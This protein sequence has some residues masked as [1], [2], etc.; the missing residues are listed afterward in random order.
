MRQCADLQC[1]AGV[2]VCSQRKQVPQAQAK[3]MPI[4]QA[5]LTVYNN[6]VA[7]HLIA[8]HTILVLAHKP[9][10]KVLLLL[11]FY[12]SLDQ[13]AGLEAVVNTEVATIVIR[14]ALSSIQIS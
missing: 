6:G 13:R 5:S 11:R 7:C 2:A 10:V 9:L 3:G 14:Q 8:Y 1:G 12:M 4:W